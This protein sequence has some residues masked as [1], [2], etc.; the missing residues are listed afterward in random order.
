V[1]TTSTPTSPDAL[2]TRFGA[3]ER[4]LHWTLAIPFLVAFATGLALYIPELAKLTGSREVVRNLHRFAGAGAVLLPLAVVL[5]GDRRAVATDVAEVD[6]WTAG[7][8]QW[9]RAWVRRRFGGRDKLPPQG[10]F[11]AGQKVNSILSAAALFWL[12]VTGALIFPGFHPPFLL[13]ENARSLHDLTWILF[14]PVLAGHIFLSAIYP[15]TRPG[16]AGMIGGKV[17]LAWLRAHHPLAVEDEAATG[18]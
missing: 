1:A 5:L 13:V 6:L 10:R 16:L 8:R 18:A 14:T 12:G 7:D 4:W 17:P 9:W 2:V 15:P 11:N 3:T